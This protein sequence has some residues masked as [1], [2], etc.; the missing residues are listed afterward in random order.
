MT[1]LSSLVL[2]AEVA[3]DTK[4]GPASPSG[5]FPGLCLC[6]KPKG[7]ADTRTSSQLEA[8]T[9]SSPPPPR[10]SEESFYGVV[11][12]PLLKTDSFG[13]DS[14]AQ[15]VRSL[16]QQQQFVGLESSSCSFLLLI[17]TQSA[18][19]RCWR[20]L[21]PQNKTS[22]EQLEEDLVEEQRNLHHTSTTS[23][24]S[25]SIE[26]RLFDLSDLQGS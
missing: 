22:P 6:Q 11:T 21:H 20:P 5:A 10:D 17:L 8:G 14:R 19:E 12:R 25:P 13:E 16:T 1:A 3:T 2:P 24:F 18:P 26:T 15:L 9:S 7:H 23:W 4:D